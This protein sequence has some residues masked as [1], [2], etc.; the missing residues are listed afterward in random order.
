MIA[1]EIAHGRQL[2]AGRIPCR[3]CA[4]RLQGTYVCPGSQAFGISYVHGCIGRRI[5]GIVIRLEELHI[6]IQASVSLHIARGIFAWLVKHTIV[7]LFRV[8][9]DASPLH[10]FFIG[11]I[12]GS[13]SF[14]EIEELAKVSVITQYAPHTL[15]RTLH[16]MVNGISRTVFLLV[17]LIYYSSLGHTF[18]LGTTQHLIAFAQRAVTPDH[19]FTAMLGLIETVAAHSLSVGKS[20]GR[21]VHN[22]RKERLYLRK[23]CRFGQVKRLPVAHGTR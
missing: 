5:N 19:D 11:F 14:T 20:D 15:H 23:V 6:I 22:I 17:H 3:L 2:L 21:I 9:C 18:S 10:Q 8:G 12:S 7:F 13:K 4:L 16:Q 1:D